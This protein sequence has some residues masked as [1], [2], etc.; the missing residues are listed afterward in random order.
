MKKIGVIIPTYNRKDLLLKLLSQIKDQ[1]TGLS[2]VE[3]IPIIVVDGSTD[4]TIEAL[5]AAGGVEIVKG[6]GSLWY[7]RSMNEGFA[8]AQKLGLNAVLTLNDDIIL[9][10]NYLSEIESIIDSSDKLDVIGSITLTMDER[11]KIFFSGIKKFIKWRQKEVKYLPKFK[12]VVPSEL[13]GEYPSFLLPGRGMLISVEALKALDGFDNVFPQYHSDGDF[14]LRAIKKGFNV[15]VSYNL[16][17]YSYIGLTAQG[18]SFKKSS[19]K[20]FLKGFVNP[21][22]RIYIP[23]VARFVFRHGVKV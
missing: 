2:S 20:A 1:E 9:A 23:Q 19:F 17:I 13:T 6:D 10:E 18:S 8:R 15:K 21:Y 4:G 5:E 14:C 11:P 22:S 12:E 16:K 7:T 3:V